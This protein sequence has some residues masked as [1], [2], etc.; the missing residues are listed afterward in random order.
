MR[1]AVVITGLPRKVKEGYESCWKK[2]I[3]KYDA[4]V[5]VQYWDG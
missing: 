2:Y 1:V 3:E 5:Y 4:D